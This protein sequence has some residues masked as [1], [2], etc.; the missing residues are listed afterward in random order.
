MTQDDVAQ[1][2]SDCEAQ[3][4]EVDRL[5][6]QYN[7]LAAQANGLSGTAVWPV[8]CELGGIGRRL[9]VA[10]DE[11]A[12]CQAAQSQDTGTS[13]DPLPHAT[14]I[15]LRT[16][17]G[18]DGA[19][20]GSQMASLWDFANASAP[21]ETVPV[22]SDAVAFRNAVPARGGITV[23]TVGDPNVVGLDFRSGP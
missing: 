14:E 18:C 4:A 1:A 8:L 5:R 21:L 20:T 11:L 10:R 9:A 15:T 6:E 17:A 2:T 13:D 3:R 16:V 23:A 7:Q 19:A 22:Q 12:A